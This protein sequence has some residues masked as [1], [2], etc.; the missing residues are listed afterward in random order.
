MAVILAFMLLAVGIMIIQLFY[1]EYH[2]GTTRHIYSIGS[3]DPSDIKVVMS[4]L[5]IGVGFIVIVAGTYLLLVQ[6]F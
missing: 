2:A 6:I 1:G 5:G 4:G 3:M